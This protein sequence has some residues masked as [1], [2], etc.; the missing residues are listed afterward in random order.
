MHLNLVVQNPTER[1]SYIAEVVLGTL[2]GIPFSI[3]TQEQDEMANI[4]YGLHKDFCIP[5]CGLLDETGIEKQQALLPMNEWQQIPT[6]FHESTNHY[7]VPFDIFSA[8]F[9]L[10][11]AYEEY[12]PHKPD[13]HSRFIPEN[14]VLVQNRLLKKPLVNL[15][16][17]ELLRHLL[18]KFPGLQHQPQQFR[19]IS[20]IDV[21]MAWKFKNK[22]VLRTSGGFVSDLLQGKWEL[23]QERFNVLIGKLPDSFCNF[24][25]Q[26]QLYKQYHT[27]NRYFI[28]LG[29]PGRFDKNIHRKNLKF[30]QLIRSL[31]NF[32]IVGIHPSYKS[33][34]DNKI[35]EA[36]ISTLSNITGKPITRSRQH[37][38]V[39]TL[40]DTF[41]LLL[42][43]GIKEDYTLGYTSHSGFRTGIAAPYKWFDVSC[44]KTTELLLFPFCHMDITPVHYE[45]KTIDEAIDDMKSFMH[46]VKMAGGLFCTLWHNESLSNSGRWKGWH[47]LF[48][49]T[50]KEA[51][52]YA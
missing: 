22:G 12:L 6:F 42:K 15:W 5:A 17:N 37:F 26:R 36:E 35:P 16:A 19:F 13:M 43:N 40:P 28:L 23:V 39:M 18:Q 20:T 45:G 33:N 41:Q 51:S 27:E 25:W 47:R 7:S 49:E 4:Y 32:S 9:Y 30:R 14:S 52:K 8:S 50:L 38:L 34:K 24:E 31:D 1:L 48:E 29:K 46:E 44:N 11:T 2:L 21:D 3:S 10:I